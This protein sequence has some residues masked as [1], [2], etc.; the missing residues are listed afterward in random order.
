MKK[1]STWAVVLVGIIGLLAAAGMAQE[2][3]KPTFVGAE[4]CAKMCHKPQ[5]DSWLTTKH[6]KAFDKLSAEEQ[7][8]PECVKCHITGA[9]PDATQLTGIQCEACHGAGSEYKKPTIMAKAKWAADPAGQMKLAQAAGL[10]VPD[11]KVCVT[12]HT[13]EGNANFKPFDFATA[14][15]KVHTMNE[16]APEKK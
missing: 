13:K 15:G 8:K 4:K 3:A 16:P 9:L 7:K 14:K 1:L 11:E 10:V 5:Y 2:K 12:C 6:A